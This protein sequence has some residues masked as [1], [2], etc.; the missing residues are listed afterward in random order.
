M[1]QMPHTVRRW[2][3]VE[4]RHAHPARPALIV[5]NWIVNLI[6][7]V[8]EVYREPGAA[9]TAPY[10]WRYMSVE[11]FAPPSAITPLDAP[12]MPVPVA[13]LLP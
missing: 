8:V 9:V 3:R 10:G 12:A 13:A 7:H 6:D 1:K 5:D 11:R 4:Y 2:K